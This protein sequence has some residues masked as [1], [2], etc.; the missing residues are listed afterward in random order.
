MASKP[1]TDINL[2]D[3]N[4]IPPGILSNGR[5][6]IWSPAS[7]DWIVFEKY[8]CE[9]N[10]RYTLAHMSLAPS[11]KNKA[12]YHRSFSETFTALKGTLGL[13]SKVRGGRFTLEPGESY[14]ISPGEVH[15]FFNPSDQDEIEARCRIE[16]AH[17]GFEKGLYVAYGLARDGKCGAEGV[18]LN[19]L[20]LAVMMTMSDI[21]L[22]GLVGVVLMPFMAMLMWIA[23]LMGVERNLVQ[24]YWVED[25]GKKQS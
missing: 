3:V 9:T 2:G 10:G 1:S 19:P 22:P 6:R 7:N 12:H 21:W 13:Y 11:G 15:Y 16:P 5:R 17:E 18:P 25:G 20:N 24:T 4:A 14:T 23:G 8:G